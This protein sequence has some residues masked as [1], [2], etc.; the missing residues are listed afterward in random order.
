MMQHDTT[1]APQHALALV[2][3][4]RE[5]QP[6]A[7]SFGADANEGYLLLHAALTEALRRRSS[8]DPKVLSEALRLL[9][10]DRAEAAA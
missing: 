5:V 3:A 1:I 9:A 6:E 8:A 7:R 4:A 2:E 10:Q